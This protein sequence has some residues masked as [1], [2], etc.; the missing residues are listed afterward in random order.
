M[1]ATVILALPAIVLAAATPAK[2]EERQLGGL[3][4]STQCLRGL[5]E[6]TQ[7]LPKIDSVSDNLF[8]Y[9]DIVKW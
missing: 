2:I 5:P 7:C 1:K 3:P 6:I 9:F 8:R 4:L